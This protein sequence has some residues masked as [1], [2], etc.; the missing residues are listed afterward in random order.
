MMKAFLSG[1]SAFRLTATAFFL[2]FVSLAAFWYCE[3]RRY[4]F[5]STD[6]FSLFVNSARMFHPSFSAWVLQGFSR[7]FMPY[8][9]WSVPSR[10]FCVRS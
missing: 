8:P 5:P 3:I 9:D 7:Y 10:I 6:E 2:S 1:L 4:Y